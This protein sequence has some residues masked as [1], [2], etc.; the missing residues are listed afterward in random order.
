MAKGFLI[1]SG[2]LCGQIIKASAEG[3]LSLAIVG[4]KTLLEHSIN[5]NYIFD[6]PNHCGDVA[7]VDR[8]CADMLARTSDLAAP[9]NR[10]ND[11]ALKTRFVEIGRPDL[12]QKNYAGLCD[13]GHLVLRAPFLNDKTNFEKQ[14]L[15]VISQS[16]CALYGV[17]DSIEAFFNLGLDANVKD[18]VISYRDRVE[19]VEDGG[20]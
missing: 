11:V 17:V 9:K 13:Y 4:H 14:T 5:A 12:Y 10:L 15:S 8:V 2:Q 18:E 7:W 6:H 16:L 3:S 20:S 1:S 19:P